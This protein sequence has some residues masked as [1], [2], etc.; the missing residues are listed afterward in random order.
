MNNRGRVLERIYAKDYTKLR[1]GKKSIY[2][3]MRDFYPVLIDYTN[4]PRKKKK[5]LKKFWMD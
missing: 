5:A 4:L 3:S 2:Y 1:L